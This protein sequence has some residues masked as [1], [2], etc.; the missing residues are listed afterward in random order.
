MVTR[1]RAAVGSLPLLRTLPIRW[2]ILSLAALNVVVAAIFMSVIWDGA[3]VLRSA[4]NELRLTRNSDRLLALLESQTGHLQSLIHRY[5]TQPNADLLKEIM[6]LRT[7]LLGTLNDRAT[8]DPILSGSAAELVRATERFVAGFG[9]LREVQETIANTYEHQVLVPAREMAGLYA[10][11]EGATRD[12]TALIWPALSKSRESFSTT[13]VLT[14]VFYLTQDRNTA[15]EVSK[16]LESVEGIIPVMMDLADNDLQRGALGALGYRAV[17]WRL[18][19]AQLAQSFAARA[20]LLGEAIDGNQLATAKAIDT[21]SESMREREERAYQRFEKT[22]SEVYL[23]IAIVALLSLTIAILIGLAITTSIV[24]PLRTLMNAMHAIVTGNY[25]RPASD[26]DARDEIGEMARAVEVFRENAIAKRQAEVE[27]QA[28]KDRA[29]R[30]L[31][32][33][34]ETQ[35][36]LI[37]AE[38]LAALGGLV[39]GVA[40]EVNNPIGISLT[41]ASSFA[42]RCDNFSADVRSGNIRR[43]KLDEFIAGS[44]EAA[45]QLVANLNRAADLIQSF[46]QVAVDRSHAE[47][48]TFDLRESTEHIVASLRPA[49]KRSSISLAV[50]IPDGILMDSYPGPYGQVLTN[51]VL[52][53]LVHGFPDKRAGSMLLAAKRLGSDQIEI[54][55][56]DDGIGMSEDVQRRAFEPFFTTRRTRGGTGLGLHIVYSLV[57]RRL[58]G[59]LRLQSEVGRGTTFKIRLPLV[60]PKDEFVDPFR[61]VS[62]AEST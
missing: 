43:S 62:L 5:F 39:A 10:I 17:S 28:S 15:E 27:L 49:L 24:Q 22:L 3:Q 44:H 40:H 59:R 34:Q 51:L 41:V 61:T 60:A 26:V 9:D 31:R 46:K 37:E 6:D 30:A 23:K 58:G 14:N 53:A 42:R 2:R 32:D 19:I 4:R 38:K 16:N 11:V 36:S 35:Q 18:G 45:K 25:A 33:L 21:L 12:R 54:Q 13:L 20:R 56:D 7:A 8:V 52:N 55:F 1:G 47:R 29:E 48:R 57:T 50:D